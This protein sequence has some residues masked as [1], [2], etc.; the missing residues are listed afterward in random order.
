MFFSHFQNQLGSSVQNISETQNNVIV[1]LE[2]IDKH[3][4]GLPINDI[5]SLLNEFDQFLASVKT[6]A[7]TKIKTKFH[8]D[9]EVETTGF[10]DIPE[11]K[12][13]E[14]LDQFKT[15][16]KSINQKIT[17]KNA[18]DMHQFRKQIASLIV[19]VE[20]LRDQIQDKNF[21]Q[22]E[23]KLL[24]K[25][26]ETL[27]KKIQTLNGTI[28]KTFN[29]LCSSDLLEDKKRTE[30]QQA[31]KVNDMIGL[32]LAIQSIGVGM[33]NEIFAASVESEKSREEVR[34][35]MKKMEAKE[36]EKEDIIKNTESTRTEMDEMKK[37]MNVSNL[38]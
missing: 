13:I 5:K 32:T 6:S 23:N 11:S 16:E 27:E 24:Q 38:T 12:F 31:F 19:Q 4:T 1:M 33:R 22:K 20:H 17:Q 2:T 21:Y 34:M 7:E 36:K 26:I 29:S 9:G 25:K 8:K 14:L 15:H 10:V 35:L 30:L 18:A 3:N 28:S 37:M